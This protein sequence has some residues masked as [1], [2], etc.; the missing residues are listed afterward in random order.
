[1]TNAAGTVTSAS[2]TA[3]VTTPTGW[4]NL[5]NATP[6]LPDTRA[7]QPFS[8]TFDPANPST[9]Y[10]ATLTSGVLTTATGGPPWS[11]TGFPAATPAL[12]VSVAHPGGALSVWASVNCTGKLFHSTNVSTWTQVTGPTNGLPAAA[13]PIGRSAIVLDPSDPQQQT[14][15]VAFSQGGLFRSTNDGATWS[16]VPLTLA[17]GITN[18]DQ[19]TA[20]TIASNG[21]AFVGT[22]PGNLFRVSGGTATLLITKDPGSQVNAIAVDP[23]GTTVVAGH[24][25]GV[26]EFAIG[27]GFAFTKG[28]T[29]IGSVAGLA[30]AV[31]GVSAGGG[32]TGSTYAVTATGTAS[33]GS[34]FRSTNSGATFTNVTA[35]TP[36]I[37]ASDYFFV[38]PHPTDGTTMYVLGNGSLS[39][40]TLTIPSSG[41]FKRTFGNPP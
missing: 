5:N 30:F 8:L 40:P 27:P 26:V 36:P 20:L 25:D 17:D 3:T 15:Y 6:T 41:F 24:A 21:T 34:V 18:D 2:A 12:R 35:A 31:D 11:G 38:A 13:C 4:V 16:K 1:M 39:T 9:L 28:A 14:L 32:I 33:G 37:D 10:A 22:A 19:P 29:L 23:G 7:A